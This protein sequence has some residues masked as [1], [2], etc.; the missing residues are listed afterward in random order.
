MIIYKDKK[1]WN[2]TVNKSFNLLDKASKYYAKGDFKKGEKYEKEAD[3]IYRRNYKKALN[4]E[5]MKKVN[6]PKSV[7]FR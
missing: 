5:E 2:K 7:F 4:I 1:L 6:S 3:E